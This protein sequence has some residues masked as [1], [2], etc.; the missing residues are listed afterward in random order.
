MKKRLC[1]SRKYPY[2]L[3]PPLEMLI[4]LHA[5]I[6]IFSRTDPLP[7]PLLKEI[8]IPVPPCGQSM[9]IF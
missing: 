6:L 7:P 2:I 8:I 1:I 9:G 5:A 4:K 3:T